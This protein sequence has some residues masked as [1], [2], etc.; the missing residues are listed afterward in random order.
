MSGRC[1]TLEGADGAY[2]LYENELRQNLVIGQLSQVVEN[3]EQVKNN[4]YTLYDEL[5][6]SNTMVNEIIN[7]LDEL[8]NETKLNTYYTQATAMATTVLTE[9][10][11]AKS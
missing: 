6:K 5:Q 4:Q 9:I 10:A 3:L 8:N 7:Q 2:N 1:D 11:V